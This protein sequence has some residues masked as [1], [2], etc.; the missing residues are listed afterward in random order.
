MYLTF[1]LI[2]CSDTQEAKVVD[3]SKFD[4]VLLLKDQELNDAYNALTDL[5]RTT[6]WNQKLESNLA[7]SDFTSKQ[8]QLIQE[9]IDI[10]NNM[11][12]LSE[13]DLRGF[14]KNWVEKAE[15]I[16]NTEQIKKIAFQLKAKNEI[17]TK[18]DDTSSA[19]RI[20]TE[21]PNHR[22]CNCN[23]GS[24]YSCDT[25]TYSCPSA[26]G[27]CKNLTASGC[28]FLWLHPCNQVCIYTVD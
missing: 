10:N 7:N 18:N 6:M 1:V 19:G 25:P 3:Q 4:A 12:N 21:D 27:N 2:G 8:R 13:V 16:F 28:G 5:E 24:L 15:K 22:S 9:L 20:Q 11:T 17:I 23:A 26:I 14:E